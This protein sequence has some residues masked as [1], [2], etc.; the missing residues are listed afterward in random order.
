MTHLSVPP[1]WKQLLRKN[2]IDWKEL[3]HF[4]ELNTDQ[5]QH[6]LKQSHFPLNLPFRIANKIPKKTLEDP[7]L[8]QFLPTIK[9]L[10]NH[11]NF[12]KTPVEDD[13]FRKESKLLQ[14]YEGRVLLVTTSACAMHCRYCFR[15]NFDYDVE[16]KSFQKEIALIAKDNS[17]HEVILSGGDPLSLNNQ[18]LESLIAQLSAIP[19]LTRIRFHTRFPIGIP[20]RIDEGFLAIL[21][22]IRQQVWF[23]IHCNHAN[24]LDEEI[25]FAL[26]KVQQTGAIVLNQ[27]VLLKGINDDKKTLKELCEALVDHGIF[28]YYINQLDRVQGSAH[29]EVE[30]QKGLELIREI[31]KELPGYAVPSY[32]REIPGEP[33]K[34]PLS[35]FYK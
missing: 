11:S 12:V 30:E 22:Q 33:N 34:T 28:P 13:K 2:F 5:K 6:I 23:V 8:K 4:L 21:R 17:I 9:E 25:L 16:N 24:E 18:T 15:Q 27:A 32:V 10:E 31:A 29:F 35:K 20:E 3:V 14:K 19:H 26:R 1:V 7:I